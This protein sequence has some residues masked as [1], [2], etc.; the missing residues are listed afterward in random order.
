VTAEGQIQLANLDRV[1]KL[2]G[3]NLVVTGKVTKWKDGN[4]L[5]MPMVGFEARCR[6]VEDSTMVWTISRTAE[7]FM[8][9]LPERK[10]NL[11]APK[12]CK[13]AIMNMHTV[14]EKSAF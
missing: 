4:L 11:A 2:L 13:D 8:S 10:A 3:A 14:N 6:S 7:V 5:F 12:V 1:A 9:S